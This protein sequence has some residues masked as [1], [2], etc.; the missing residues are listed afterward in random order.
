MNREN[1]FLL[2]QLNP[3]KRLKEE[4]PKEKGIKEKHIENLF[5]QN[6]ENIFFGWISLS[7]QQ[8]LEH[9]EKDEENCIVDSLAFNKS[10]KDFLVIEYK[11]E[12]AAELVYQAEKYMECLEDEEKGICIRNR[13]KLVDI[14]NNNE[15]FKKT[16]SIWKEEEIKWDE[17]KA[18]CIITEIHNYQ[19]ILKRKPRENIHVIEIKF[20]EDNLL[21]ID[22]EKLPDWLKIGSQIIRNSTSEE[23]PIVS[24]FENKGQVDQEV[25]ELF[26]ELEKSIFSLGELEKKEWKK[27]GYDPRL[28][29]YNKDTNKVLVSLIV[30]IRKINVY[31]NFESPHEISQNLKSL[32]EKYNAL[33]KK[34]Q[35]G[36]IG[37]WFFPSI[38]N[39][40]SLQKFKEFILEYKNYCGANQ[41]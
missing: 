37:P 23:K 18:I 39:E 40:I 24:I 1:K 7:Q 14:L 21:Y 4:K 12:K 11:R 13:N 17:T 5:C 15:A 38:S 41:E 2:Y 3:L 26:T 27:E 30:R 35:H 28:R 16:K 31:W 10:G 36:V 29:Y 33:Y 8:H 22:C 34:E 6:L 25:G 20:Y 32:M 19:K 9:P